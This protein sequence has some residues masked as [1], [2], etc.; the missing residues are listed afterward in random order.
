MTF[1]SLD[2]LGWEDWD[3]DLWDGAE[4]LPDRNLPDKSDILWLLDQSTHRRRKTMDRLLDT[5]A[6]LPPE[7]VLTPFEADEF[8]RKCWIRRMV[9]YYP[10]AKRLADKGQWEQFMGL[11]ACTY[12]LMPVVFE[13]EFHDMPED[14]RAAFALECYSGH[15]DAVLE[16]RE[17]VKKLPKQGAQSLPDAFAGQ[18]EITIYR[19][20]AEPP[21]KAS[22]ALSWT[23]DRKIAE[24][25]LHEYV[26]RHAKYL[27]QAT[28]R[29]SDVIGCITSRD[30]SEIVQFRNIRNLQILEEL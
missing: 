27:Y 10:R 9:S 13:R 11:V 30:E 26:Q 4:E 16:V 14:L 24:W 18:P 21:E 7:G 12:Q 6:P 19:A 22:D 25:F 3:L 5:F 29:P 2:T 23:W 8:F 28:I 1:I 20:G 15:G 17:A